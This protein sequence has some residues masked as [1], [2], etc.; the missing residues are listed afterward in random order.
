MGNVRKVN[1]GKDFE[2]EIKSCLE[3]CQHVS[4]DR[5][6]D[7]MSGYKGSKNIC[8]YS[9]FCSPD[10]FYLECKSKYGNTLNYKGD[11]S[12]DQWNGLMEKSRI[13][14]CIAGICIWYIDHDITVFCDIR[15][16]NEHRLN[17]AKS[18]NIKDITGENCVPHFIIDGIKKRVKFKY[19]GESFLRNLHK[20]SDNTWGDKHE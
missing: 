18:L 5:L 17:G 13:Y 16:L 8:D 19:F 7:Q 3:I 14:R 15:D 2:F 4:L 6:P 20:L 11:V 1:R 10:M 9:M 12:E